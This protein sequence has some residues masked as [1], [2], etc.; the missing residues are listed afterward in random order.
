MSLASHELDTSVARSTEPYKPNLQSVA[1]PLDLLKEEAH[2]TIRLDRALHFIHPEMI[3]TVALPN[4]CRLAAKEQT[5]LKLAPST[6]HARWIVAALAIITGHRSPHR[7]RSTFWATSTFL[8]STV[9]DDD[10]NRLLAH[11][12]RERGFKKGVQAVIIRGWTRDVE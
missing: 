6:D 7:S 11:R 9:V 8:S 4:T 10:G 12:R 2:D 1:T 5:S 3:E